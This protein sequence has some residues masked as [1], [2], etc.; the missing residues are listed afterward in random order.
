MVCMVQLI[1]QACLTTCFPIIQ[2]IASD[3]DIHQ[4]SIMPWVV[5]AYS[6]S[7]GTTILLAGRLGDIFGH[8][9]MVILGFCWLSIF[10][11][12][13]GAS[14]Y[15]NYELFF[16]A[17]AFQGVGAAMM[18]PNALALLGR[19]Y[20]PGSKRKI[21]AFSAFALCA[22]L[23][24]YSGMLFSALIGQ[25]AHWSWSFYTTA[26]ICFI[27]AVLSHFVLPTPLKTPKQLLPFRQKLAQMDWL[28]GLTG[29]AGLVAVQVSLIC[30]PTE[31]WQTQYIFML[32]ILG[33][34]FLGFF[35]LIELKLASAPLVPFA[36]LNADAAFVLTAIACGWATFGTW[37]YYLWRFL[38]AV[39]HLSP[40]R[41]ALYTLPII[42]VALI[43]A[44]L[45]AYLM[46]T[47]RP[48]WILFGALVAFTLGPLF[49]SLNTG[50]HTSY[51]AFTFVSL[52]VTPFG[53][54]MSFPSATFVMSNL[55]PVDRQGVAGSLVTTVV[56]YSISLG[57]GLACTVEVHVN[58]NGG[59]VMLGIRGGW[60]F[61]VGIGLLGVLVCLGFVF[62]TRG[63]RPK[64]AGVHAVTTADVNF[65]A[66]SLVH[67]QARRSWTQRLSWKKRSGGDTPDLTPS[68]AESQMEIMR[69]ESR[70]KRPATEES[71]T[72]ELVEL[73]P[74]RSRSS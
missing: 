17:R 42:P 54:D 12:V 48:A 60:W 26:I 74:S 69:G 58:H 14:R 27:L 11:V 53:M 39:H 29:V 13:A 8:R 16:V 49:M 32:F 1:P 70:D 50:A 24:A 65:D 38:L 41:A 72:P 6:L 23:G 21:I 33:V 10:S 7:F 19:S 56:N 57:L 3:F 73:S 51:W 52:L 71:K 30:A 46:R 22:P 55:L 36:L 18:N 43:A 45:T 28:G 15:V 34:C 62:R 47:T 63:H 2:I 59:D 20:P 61:G 35:V 4:A 25:L 40:L 44:A 66:D 68:R 31:G 67:G 37:T 5:A 64:S 9:A